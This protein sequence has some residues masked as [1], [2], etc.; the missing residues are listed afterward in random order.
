MI[1]KVTDV[2]LVATILRNVPVPQ[3]D[4]EWNCVFWIRDA[5]KSL[6]GSKKALGTRQMDWKKVRDTALNFC[7]EKKASHRFDGKG[8]IGSFD[9][10]QAPTYDLL[11]ER[12]TI[13]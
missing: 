5:L 3:D 4:P 8:K 9:P 7:E 13:P 10:A 2:A 12:E 6:D 11:E 1:A